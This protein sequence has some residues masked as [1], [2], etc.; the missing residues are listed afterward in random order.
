ML[1]KQEALARE[2]DALRDWA[3]D[4][5]PIVNAAMAMLTKRDR[6]HGSPDVPAWWNGHDWN[7]V[8]TTR[9]YMDKLK[10]TEQ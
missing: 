2:L 6:E 9:L 5:R 4:V 3:D 1:G 7:L 10:E 8:V